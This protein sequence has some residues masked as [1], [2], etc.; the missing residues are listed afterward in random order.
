[1]IC[2]V[3]IIIFPVVFDDDIEQMLINQSETA[4]LPN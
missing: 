3:L 4:W 2:P 1:M